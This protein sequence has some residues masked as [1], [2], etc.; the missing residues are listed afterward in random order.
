MLTKPLDGHFSVSDKSLVSIIAFKTAQVHRKDNKP[1]GLS[2]HR[3]LAATS[4]WWAMPTLRGW[5]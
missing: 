3:A 4:W 2:R 1:G 5:A